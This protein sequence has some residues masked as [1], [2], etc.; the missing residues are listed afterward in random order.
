MDIEFEGSS[1]QVGADG[2]FH[3]APGTPDFD[4]ARVEAYGKNLCVDQHM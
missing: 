2:S 3:A 4:P 1:V